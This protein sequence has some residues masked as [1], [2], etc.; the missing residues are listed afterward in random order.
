M[1]NLRLKIA[2]LLGY[3]TYADYVLADRMAE[4]AQ[5]V[6]AFPHDGWP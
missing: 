2:N 6:N 3:P 5:T 4:N 1:V